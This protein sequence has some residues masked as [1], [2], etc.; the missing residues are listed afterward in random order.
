MK[1]CQ[2]YFIKDP[3]KLERDP[4]SLYTMDNKELSEKY[5]FKPDE[6]WKLLVNAKVR[7]E[8][9]QKQKFKKKD[10]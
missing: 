3:T 7:K 5:Q 10:I 2:K 9:N 4:I 1:N 8:I 6:D